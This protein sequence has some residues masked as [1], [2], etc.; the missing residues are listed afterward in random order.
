MNEWLTY[1]F[2]EDCEVLIHDGEAGVNS[3][4]WINIRIWPITDNTMR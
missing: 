2:G 1:G 4:S 3:P